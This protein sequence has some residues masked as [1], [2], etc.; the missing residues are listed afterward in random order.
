M[1]GTGNS[2]NYKYRVYD[3]RIGKFLSIDPLAPD[4][5]WNSPY[6]FS[7]NRVIDMLELEGLEAIS[8][9]VNLLRTGT[10]IAVRTSRG[11]SEFVRPVQVPRV[12]PRPLPQ[13]QDHHLIP[14]Q[15]RNTPEVQGAM[16][17]GFKFDGKD[18]NLDS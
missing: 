3:P 10:R 15:F 16:R 18:N 6:A 8:P 17:R 9:W 4:Y 1:K 2:I 13:F 7:E 11:T 12:T 14:Q 5:P